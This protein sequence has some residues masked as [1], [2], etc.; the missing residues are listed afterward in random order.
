M[1]WRTCRKKLKGLRRSQT[2]TLNSCKEWQ[3]QTLGLLPNNMNWKHHLW[4]I[5]RGLLP[6]SFGRFFRRVVL[7]GKRLCAVA[8]LA[9][10][11]ALFVVPCPFCSKYQ[12]P[13]WKNDIMKK[14]PHFKCD[15][16]LVNVWIKRQI[17]VPGSEGH[18]DCSHTSSAKDLLMDST[19][20]KE[21]CLMVCWG[22]KPAETVMWKGLS[23]DWEI[24]NAVASIRGSSLFP[25]DKLTS[26]HS[27]FLIIDSPNVLSLL[28]A[29]LEFKEASA[30]YA[31]NRTKK[32]RIVV[33]QLLPQIWTRS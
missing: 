13:N 14:K 25:H 24:W 18:H 5:R 19:D 2:D 4:F 22:W 30:L 6:P 3:S 1:Q 20:T 23:L 31:R 28:S 10:T 8:V 15:H 29:I 17:H 12:P 33:W 27:K 21:N 26:H 16:I 9:S 7:T 11:A 32:S